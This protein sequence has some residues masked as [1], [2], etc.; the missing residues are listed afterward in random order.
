MHAAPPD[1]QKLTDSFLYFIK[2]ISEIQDE[3]EKTCDRLNFELQEH[4]NGIG[5]FY[6]LV[7]DVIRKHRKIESEFLLLSY[8]LRAILEN[9]LAT[10]RQFISE[11]NKLVETKN[12]G[13]FR[14]GQV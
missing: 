1:F 7:D 5:E 6:G 14:V 13:Q 4:E 3:V 9:L 11:I 2:Y 10:Y 12:E 8:E